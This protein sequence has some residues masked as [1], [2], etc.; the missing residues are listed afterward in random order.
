MTT[1]YDLN[2][3]NSLTASDMEFIRQQ[4]EEA[5]RTLSDAVTGLLNVPQGWRI[6][7]EYRAEFGGLFPVQCRLSADGCDDYHLCVC[8]PGEVT[9]CW[10]LVLLSSGGLIVRTLWQSERFEPA[11]LDQLVGQVAGMRR[12]HC[13]ASTVADLM[14]R[15]VSV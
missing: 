9:P 15:E 13:T 1:I 14:S 11:R 8:S 10:L 4:G 2:R 12:F 7:A 3:I 6:C 5:R